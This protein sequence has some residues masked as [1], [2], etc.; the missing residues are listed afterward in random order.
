MLKMPDSSVEVLPAPAI[1]L[2]NV[3]KS[4]RLY[5]SLRDQALDV[6]G[7]R[8]RFTSKAVEEFKAL[9]NINL[10]IAKGEQV[11]VIG[12]NGAGKTTLLKMLIRNF[13]PT[14]G[15]VAV[16]GTVQAL[17]QTGLGFHPDFTGEENLRSALV[18]N[19]LKGVQFDKAL[20]DAIEFVELDEF[21]RQ[22]FKT[23]SLGMRGRLQFAA[24][25]AIH[26]DILIVDEVLGAGDAYFSGKSAARMKS[27]MSGGCTLLLVSHSMQQILQFCQRCIWLEAGEIV[28]DGPALPTVRAYEEYTRR[29]ESEAIMARSAGRKSILGDSAVQKKLVLEVKERNTAVDDSNPELDATKAPRWPSQNDDLRISKLRLI[30]PDGQPTRALRAGKAV[31]IEMDVVARSDGPF[32]AIFAHVIYRED[33]FVAARL[34][35]EF[36]TLN[37]LAGQTITIV[38]STPC[39]RFG[40]GKYVISTSI[41]KELDVENATSVPYDV[42]SR[43]MDFSVVAEYRN[44]PSL[45][46]QDHSWNLR[47]PA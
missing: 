24:A 5:A 15:E 3:G 42:I 1:V 10:T 29:L 18:Y 25:T 13:A 33:G 11:G 14:T 46:Y 38:A 4:Y 30:G 9:K 40:G 22:P 36:M 27:L 6:L 44:D 41:Y 12:R 31:E 8:V 43:C 32:R 35:S 20:A 23:Y 26:P 19:G 47:N 39:L 17:M 37:V 34:I 2:S 16:N 28:M 21:L 45:F 7:I